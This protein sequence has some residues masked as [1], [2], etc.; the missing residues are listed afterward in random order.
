MYDIGIRLNKEK[1]PMTDEKD[2]EVYF[3]SSFNEPGALSEKQINVKGYAGC[4]A[5]EIEFKEAL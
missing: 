2:K 5:V 1:M 3:P 4:K